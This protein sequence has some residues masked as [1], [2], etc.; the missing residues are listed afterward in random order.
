MIVGIVSLGDTGLLRW[1][2]SFGINFHMNAD[3]CCDCHTGGFRVI[4]AY[5]DNRIISEIDSV[6]VPAINTV[7]VSGN[8]CDHC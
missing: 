2:Q 3:D 8:R 7:V 4:V 1:L 6:S 5:P